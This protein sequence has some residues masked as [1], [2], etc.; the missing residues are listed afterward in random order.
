LRWEIFLK[1]ILR[2]GAAAASACL[3]LPFVGAQTLVASST[4]VVTGARLAQ[5]AADSPLDLRVIER[6]QIERAGVTGLAELLR[7]F[8]GV[9]ISATGGAGQPSGLFLRGSNT[10]HVLLL[11]DGVR[12]NSA[13]TGSNAFEHLALDQIERVE[14]L[15]GPASGLY[16]ADAIGGVV[17]VFTRRADGLS[18][19]VGAGGEGTRKASAS[20]GAASG[21]TRGSLTVG[22]RSS[23]A[24]SATNPSH[25]FSYNPDTDPYRNLSVS[26]WLEHTHAPGRTLALRGTRSQARTHFDA[27]P[28]SDDLNRQRLATLALESRDRIAPGWTSVL[29]LARGSDDI[30]TEGSFPGGFRTDQDQLTWQHDVE[31]AGGVTAAGVEWRRERV[32]SS[33]A[34]TEDA[35]RVASLFGGWTGEVA[36][37]HRLQLALRHDRNSQFGGRSTGNL[38]WSHGVAPGLRVTA[39]AGTAFKAPSFN[40]LYYPLQFG[41]S[42]N[43]DLRPERS[44][45]VEGG[46]RY[47]AGGLEAGLTAFDN[48]I[49]DLI[50]VNDSFTTVENVARARIRGL[51]LQGRWTAGPWSA[52]AEATWQSPRNR[53][54]GAQL[55]RRAE[56]FGSAGLDWTAGDWRV[57]AEWAA[58]GARYDDGA[59]S[60]AARLGGY[61]LLNLTAGWTPAP[62]WTLAASLDN[63]TDRAYTLVR[64]YDTPG[65]RLFVS[66]AWETR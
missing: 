5:P 34:F 44:R 1:P 57:G 29:R 51:T 18:A 45:S 19:R 54:T 55:V 52:R 56:R 65:R 37:S 6:A 41:Y 42:G 61:A 20:L 2:V 17:Q 43:P 28:G 25:P 60:P 3:F 48:R 38:G 39:A 12:V 36:P 7:Q 11:V 49:D 30:R 53:D 23:D 27:G 35:R 9:E 22:W 8:G 64:G 31:L 24:G 13:T 14:V 66:L 15:L 59:N 50:V 32:D 33:T 46:L 47:A 21:D 26:G 10:S 16:G 40:D 63:A 4:I 62:G 58:A